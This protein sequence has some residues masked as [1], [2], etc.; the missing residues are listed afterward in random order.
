MTKPSLF[1]HPQFRFF[2]DVIT[3]FLQPKKVT[4]FLQVSH[5]LVWWV[6]SLHL[7]SNYHPQKVIFWSEEKPDLWLAEKH[8]C[9]CHI[10]GRT[11]FMT[12]WPLESDVI[13]GAQ[14]G[15][16]FILKIVTQILTKAEH[17]LLIT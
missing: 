14:R 9:D 16:Q 12:K 3:E 17:F 15:S 11:G 13:K 2:L 7:K 4:D 5:E 8:I 10:A 1:F 6:L